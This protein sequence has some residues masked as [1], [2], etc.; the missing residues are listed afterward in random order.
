MSRCG[1]RNL[2]IVQGSRPPILANATI[3]IKTKQSALKS[4][5]DPNAH[6]FGLTPVWS[7]ALCLAWCWHHPV[8][9]DPG[10]RTLAYLPMVPDKQPL[11]S[12]SSEE[13]SQPSTRQAAYCSSSQYRL[14]TGWHCS[15]RHEGQTGVTCA[16][17]CLA[18]CFLFQRDASAGPHS[19]AT[20]NGHNCNVCFATKA[21]NE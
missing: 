5:S 18:S 3:R 12:C 8:L 14:D 10:S 2:F 9:A 13:M 20:R 19:P 7:C 4:G 6:D 21:L 17:Y 11:V 1:L 15:G 16:Q